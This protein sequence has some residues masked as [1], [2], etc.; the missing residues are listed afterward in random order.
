MLEDPADEAAAAKIGNPRGPQASPSGTA[1]P[2]GR[3]SGA[4]TTTPAP[5]SSRS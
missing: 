3:R 5:R 1:P 4:G 2:G